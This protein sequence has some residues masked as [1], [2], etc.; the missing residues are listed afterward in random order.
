M[1]YILWTDAKEYF[2]ED[3]VE[4]SGGEIDIVRMTEFIDYVEKQLDNRLRRYMTVPVDETES[5]GAFAQV[6]D[7]C[8]MRSAAMYLR[9][10]YSAEGT[11]ESTWWADQLDRDAESAIVSLTTGR[12]APTDAEDATSPLQYVPTDGKAESSTEPDALF[13]RTQVPGGS[14]AW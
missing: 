2:D 4:L 11:A 1:S 6:K 10:A 8:A 13:T 5:P 9:V 7:V 3:A 12:S 14:E